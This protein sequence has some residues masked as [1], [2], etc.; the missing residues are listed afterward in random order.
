MVVTRAAEGGRTSDRST[1][2]RANWRCLVRANNL[3]LME[4]TH[5]ASR[6][7]GRMAEDRDTVRLDQLPTATEQEVSEYSERVRVRVGRG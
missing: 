1:E 3:L 2:Q 4:R 5:Q 7:S 6:T